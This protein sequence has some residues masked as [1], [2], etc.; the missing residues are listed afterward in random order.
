MTRLSSPIRALISV[1]V[2][3]LAAALSHQSFTLLGHYSANRYITPLGAIFFLAAASAWF[4]PDSPP[5]RVM[6]SLAPALVM[7]GFA[8]TMWHC[9]K[10]I[11]VDGAISG[12][13]TSLIAVGIVVVYRANRI[14][15][16]AQAQ[17]GAL[18]AS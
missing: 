4:L 7:V 13:M 2:I 16:F 9:S 15:N 1:A 5:R 6:T 17:M 3:G 8:D 10:D 11:L 12:L 18:P 14:V